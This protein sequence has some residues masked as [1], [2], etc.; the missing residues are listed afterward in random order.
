VII[1]PEQSE[2]DEL[3]KFETY[4]KEQLNVRKITF[5]TDRSS[6]GIELKAE[7]EIPILG[8]RLGK[9]AKDVFAAIRAL[10]STQI[11]QLKESG[12]MIVGG[13]EIKSNEIRIQF[14]VK[15]EVKSTIS[16]SAKST[17]LKS[18]NLTDTFFKKI[19]FPIVMSSE[20]L[21]FS[22]KFF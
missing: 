6:Y 19:N 1:R 9:Q 22:K 16:L 12:S 10:N 4:I 11:D 5:S 14:N 15:A 3:A 20:N 21:K 17:A 7:P 8:R 13:H 18:I 2:L